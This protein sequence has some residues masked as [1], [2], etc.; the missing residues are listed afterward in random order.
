VRN[1]QP[2]LRVSVDKAHLSFSMYI[3][4]STLMADVLPLFFKGI[5]ENNIPLLEF[6]LAP[7]LSLLEDHLLL[8]GK[9]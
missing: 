1:A 8:F 9:R 6:G 7:L 3:Q 5:E 4:G 2:F